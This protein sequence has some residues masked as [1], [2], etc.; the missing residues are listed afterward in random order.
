MNYEQAPDIF[1]GK[2]LNYLCDMFHWHYGAY[3]KTVNRIDQVN[4]QEIQD[5]MRK[6]SDAFY[7]HMQT[8]LDILNQGG[9]ESDE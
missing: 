4:D 7:N 2:D 9:T 1:T 8:I 5:M 3:K 6:C